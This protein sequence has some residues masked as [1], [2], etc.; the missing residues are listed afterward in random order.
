MFLVVPGHILE[1]PRTHTLGCV[2]HNLGFGIV[3]GSIAK[4]L[5]HMGTK[6]FWASSISL[7][8]K[9]QIKARAE[10]E[11]KKQAVVTTSLDRKLGEYIFY[12]FMQ[13]LT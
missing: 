1:L 3:L 8:K 4:D 11:K 7:L 10:K 12:H 5:H 13:Y 2:M 9:R 6:C